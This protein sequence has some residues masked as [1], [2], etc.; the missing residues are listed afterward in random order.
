MIGKIHSLNSGELFA[1]C[2]KELINKTLKFNDVEI[3]ISSNF[4][5]TKLI[6]KKELLDCIKSCNQVNIFGN[7][8]CKL[9]I[10]ENMII[11][12]QIIY[13]EDIAHVQIYNLL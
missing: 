6:S 5:G 11:S 10:E 2:D 8:I 7:K 4:Y 12:E 1:C 9:L 3:N 13:I